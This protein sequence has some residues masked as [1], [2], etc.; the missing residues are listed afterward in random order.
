MILHAPLSPIAVRV[1]RKEKHIPRKGQINAFTESKN[2]DA[3]EGRLFPKIIMY[4]L[5]LILS[6]LIQQMFNAIDLV[7]LGN[8]ADETALASVDATTSIVSLLVTSFVGLASGTRVVLA[9]QIGARDG[10]NVRRAT[11][12]SLILSVVLGII[13][14]I[15]GFIFAPWFLEITNCPGECVEGALLYVR[16]YVSVA[17]V[18]FAL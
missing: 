5:P 9:R 10:E 2:I 1:V 17:P 11:D 4:A 12:T 14:A 18:Y 15:L 7:V 3:T 6:T 8:M 13:L 16:I